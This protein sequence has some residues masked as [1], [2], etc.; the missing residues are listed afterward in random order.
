MIIE[1]KEGHF[2]VMEQEGAVNVC[3][4]I[5]SDI[6]KPLSF[7][8]TTQDQSATGKCVMQV[9]ISLVPRPS[10]SSLCLTT[11]EKRFVLKP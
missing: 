2:S 10:H 3:V 1:L 5:S 8:I 6:A 4:A 11:V 9:A 7:T